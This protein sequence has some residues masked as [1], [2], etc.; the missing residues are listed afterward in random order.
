MALADVVRLL[1]EI[2]QHAQK[3]LYNLGSGF[4]SSH[5]L[6]ANWLGRQGVEVKL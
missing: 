6:V 5:S 4:N 2:A 3:R 1:P